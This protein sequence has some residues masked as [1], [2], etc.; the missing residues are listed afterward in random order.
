MR[1]N[2]ELAFLASFSGSL[3]SSGLTAFK[4]SLLRRSAHQAAQLSC[5]TPF[6]IPSLEKCP[7]IVLQPAGD[8]SEAFDET[9]SLLTVVG[10]ES[11][12]AFLAQVFP[13]FMLAGLGMVAAGLLLNNVQTWPVFVE[14]SELF[15]LVPALLGLKGNLEMTLASRLATQAN[16][17]KADSLRDIVGLAV[18]N[19]TLL[20]C[21]SVVV[22][23]LASMYAVLTSL[24][25]SNTV[26]LRVVLLVFASSVVTASVASLV[27][28]YILQQVQDDK[29][30]AQKQPVL[31]AKQ[32]D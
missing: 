32:G 23:T 4:P 9:T 17:G 6:V 18:G 10:R 19:M 31:H 3:F 1:G 12:C 16:L 2:D 29:C 26:T 22:G 5:G 24:A 13:A 15:I 28:G 7:A 30:A 14:A 11:R 27:L 25:L 20:Q 8:G 21:Q